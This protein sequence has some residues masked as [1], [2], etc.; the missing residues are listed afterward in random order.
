M[1][2]KL[3]SFDI[4]ELQTYLLLQSILFIVLLSFLFVIS[5]I[6]KQGNTS[7]MANVYAFVFSSNKKIPTKGGILLSLRIQNLPCTTSFDMVKRVSGFNITS[8]VLS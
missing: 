3:S 8:D 2:W 4:Q 5:Y 1:R 7:K 6:V